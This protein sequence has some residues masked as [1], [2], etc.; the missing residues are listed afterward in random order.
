MVVVVIMEIKGTPDSVS[1]FIKD[2]ISVDSIISTC[3]LITLNAVLQI[4]FHDFCAHVGELTLSSM[5]AN[6]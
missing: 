5:F 4:Y 2:C 6:D 3:E 1:A